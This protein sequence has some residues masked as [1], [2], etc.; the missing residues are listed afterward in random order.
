MAQGWSQLE[1]EAIVGD[2]LE[3]L[4]LEIGGMPYNKSEHRRTLKPLLQGRSDPSIERKHQNISAVLRDMGFPFIDG[5]KPLGNYQRSLLPEV[6]GEAVFAHPSLLKVIE[7]DVDRQARVPSVDDILRAMLSKPPASDRAVP[8]APQLPA[9]LLPNV[10][11]LEREFRNRSLGAAG[12]QF[13]VNYERARLAHAGQERLVEDVEWVSQ[14]RGDGLG[15]DV[16]SFEEGG[17]ERFIEVK[18]TRYGKQT[19]FFISPNELRFCE[20]HREAFYLYRVFAFKSDPKMFALPGAIESHCRL[21]PSEYRAT[22][23]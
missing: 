11:Y 13:V 8:M 20:R 10:N 19:P 16:R 6:V 14:T 5:Y 4:S 12:E 21:N 23:L 7:A 15:Y 3:M 9:H 17:Q 1:V 18:T 2:Y 22:L